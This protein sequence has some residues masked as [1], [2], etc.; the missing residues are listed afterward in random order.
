MGCRE[1]AAKSELLR[2]VIGSEPSGHLAA[3]PDPG[4]SA[5]GRGAHVHPTLEC[6]DLA[7][8]KR[9]FARALRVPGGLPSVAV[10]DYLAART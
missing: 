9:A 2:V 10:R 7:E 1:R 3:R 5:A 6:Y 8:R 4:G